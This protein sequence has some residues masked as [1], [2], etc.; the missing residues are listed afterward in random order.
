MSDDIISP[1]PGDDQAVPPPPP[2]PPPQQP[3]V[4][5]GRGTLLAIGVVA[6]LYAGIT[7]WKLLNPAQ[8]PAA[9]IKAVADVANPGNLPPSE[10]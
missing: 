3:K 1:V 9:P 4:L 6:A 2:P 8:P 10:N 5:Y 7:A